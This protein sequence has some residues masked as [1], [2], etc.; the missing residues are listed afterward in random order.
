M[1]LR[2]A[3]SLLELGLWSQ[4]FEFSFWC[5]HLLAFI[6]LLKD[7]IE[8]SCV[9]AGHA[10]LTLFCSMHK[11]FLET[12]M[13]PIPKWYMHLFLCKMPPWEWQS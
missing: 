6:C 4:A 8:G 7:K 11:D 2:A 10:C 3:S 9:N 12:E 1:K 13:V 5:I